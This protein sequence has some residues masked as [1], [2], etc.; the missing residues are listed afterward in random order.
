MNTD[1]LKETKRRVDYLARQ[2]NDG[3]GIGFSVP[4]PELQRPDSPVLNSVQVLSLM[5]D[6]L[7]W[8]AYLSDMED[9]GKIS[10]SE[11]ADERL[12]KL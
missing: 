5:R 7:R 2:T 3:R 12:G 6:G 10:R 1:D 4:P 11:V 9:G 8:R